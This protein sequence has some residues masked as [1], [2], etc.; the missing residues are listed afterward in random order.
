[1][2][3]VVVSK[4]HKLSL[5]EAKK[6]VDTLASNLSKKYELDGAWAGDRYSF[7]RTA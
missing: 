1:M 4:N 2:P 6:R 5:A 3:K 7:K